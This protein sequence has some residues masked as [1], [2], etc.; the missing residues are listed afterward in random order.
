MENGQR[1]VN[2]R[3]VGN[4]QGQHRVVCSLFRRFRH[5]AVVVVD[6]HAHPERFDLNVLFPDVVVHAAR[7][8]VELA[9]RV[10]RVDGQAQAVRPRRGE[11]MEN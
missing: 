6:H 10:G 11:L 7:T 2:P 5:G 3:I 4:V 8:I 9:D 1:N